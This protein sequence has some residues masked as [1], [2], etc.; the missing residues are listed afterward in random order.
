[1]RT[2]LDTRY[3]LVERDA[4]G[5]VKERKSVSE[6]KYA[7]MLEDAK[8]DGTTEPE[9]EK[10][11]TFMRYNVESQED[12]E[13]LVPDLDERLNIINRTLDIK[14]TDF[15]RDLM[16]SAAFQA[17]EGTYDLADACAAK[18]ERK[19][20]SPLEKYIRGAGKLSL[21]D[22]QELVRR[23]QALAGSTVSA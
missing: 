20:A 18:S 14:Q 2:E 21:E 5:G 1:M 9:R 16:T 19:S 13:I 3:T 7:S 11:K 23:L 10:S 8:T 12:F 17:E 6:A 22:Q 15:M 4:S